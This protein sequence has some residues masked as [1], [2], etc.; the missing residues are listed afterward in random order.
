VGSRG[1]VAE[2]RCN[3][4]CPS[5]DV[6][7]IY[8]YLDMSKVVRVTRSGCKGQGGGWEPKL[9]RVVPEGGSSAGGFQAA[10]VQ[11]DIYTTRIDSDGIFVI[12][13]A[14]RRMENF[15]SSYILNDN[16]YII[17]MMDLKRLSSA[18]F[19]SRFLENPLRKIAWAPI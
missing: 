12:C 13:L 2:G 6:I 4:I 5:S 7:Y 18:N 19:V 8:I 10:A 3:P 16:F 1:R 9:T 17:I 14:T 15:L 11:R